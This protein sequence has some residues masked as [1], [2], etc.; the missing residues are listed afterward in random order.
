MVEVFF[1]TG[2]GYKALIGRGALEAL[3]KTALS[4]AAGRKAAVVTERNVP[5]QYAERAAAELIKAGFDTSLLVLEGGEE[6]KNLASVSEIYGFLAERR[7]TRA[8]VLVSVGGG[9]VGDAAGFAAATYLRGTGHIAVPTT[10]IAQT[11]SAYGGKTGVDHAGI[12][13]GIGCFADPLAVVC[14]TELLATLPERERANGMGEIVKYGAIAEP[15]ILEH[16]SRGLPDDETVARCVLIK[17]RF[18]ESDEFDRGERHIL[19][20]GHTWGH[21]IEEATGYSVP[22]GQAVAYGMLAAVRLGEKLGVTA[23]GVFCAVES[24]LAR[25]GLATGHASYL[26]EA[27]AFLSRDKKSDGE[28]I[29]AVLLEEL[30]KPV[31]MKLSAEAIAEAALSAS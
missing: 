5:G 27:A 29:D 17:R 16:V 19:N 21:A 28:L 11:D 9:V 26:K 18:V 30:G 8:D 25:A 14:D 13:N 12:K 6:H 31:R 4:A 23:P 10:V 15:S 7:F 22:H 2:R 3:G 20:F 1:N 24:A